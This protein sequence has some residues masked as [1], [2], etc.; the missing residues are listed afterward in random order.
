[1][2]RPGSRCLGPRICRRRLPER[3]SVHDGPALIDSGCDTGARAC[4]ARACRSRGLAA[5]GCEARSLGRRSTRRHIHHR[6][7]PIREAG[8]KRRFRGRPGRRVGKWTLLRVRAGTGAGDGRPRGGVGV[9]R[10]RADPGTVRSVIVEQQKCRGCGRHQ[11]EDER[12]IPECPSGTD[13]RKPPIWPISWSPLCALARRS[14]SFVAP[15]WHGCGLA[16][17]PARPSPGIRRADSPHLPRSGHNPWAIFNGYDVLVQAKLP[18]GPAG[19]RLTLATGYFVRGPPHGARA[20]DSAALLPRQ[21]R[22][23]TG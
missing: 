10:G 13:H 14:G 19:R 23:S 11:S 20:V 9:R 4:R 18:A 15:L 12:H 16:P 17:A 8:Q 1:M 6:H 3:R 5:P 21:R 7:R 2:P 22:R